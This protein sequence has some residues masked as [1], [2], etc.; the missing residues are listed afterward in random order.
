MGRIGKKIVE[1]QYT[2]DTAA[3]KVEKIMKNI[4]QGYR[5]EN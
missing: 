3:F 2:W 5:N 4:L 1:E